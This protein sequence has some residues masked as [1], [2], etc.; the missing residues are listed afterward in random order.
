MST[1]DDQAINERMARVES[2]LRRQT[3]ILV[4]TLVGGIATPL[5]LA[6]APAK[7]IVEAEDFKLR[8]PQGQ[9]LAA[10][11]RAES[12]ATLILFDNHHR[13]RFVV[14]SA[15]DSSGAAF[16]GTDQKSAASIEVN[17]ENRPVISLSDERGKTR[18]DLVIAKQGPAMRLWDSNSSIRAVVG[19]DNNLPVVT[20][21]SGPD[22]KKGSVII[23]SDAKGGSVLITGPDGKS[24]NLVR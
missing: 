4:A 9:E 1:P 16:L 13:A 19:I 23:G 21:S 2:R 11:D 8:G 17:D 15:D 14:L 18:A 3:Q 22:P 10:L 7:R 24:R 20:V 6:Q 12:G 5:L